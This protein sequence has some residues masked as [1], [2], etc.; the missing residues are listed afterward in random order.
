MA[1]GFRERVELGFESWGR[2]VAARPVTVLVASL[3]FAAA[4][5]SGLPHLRIDVSFEAFLPADDPVRVAY[6]S[7]REQFG[8]DE[9]V[10]IAAAPGGAVSAGDV[11]DLAFLEKLRAFHEAIEERIPYVDEITSLVN[12]RDTRGE[13]DLL[14][15]DDFL[16]PWPENEEQLA[17]LRERALANPLFRNNVISSDA[18]VTTLVL[19]LQLYSSIGAPDSENDVLAGFEAHTTESEEPPP[20]LSSAEE[21]EFVRALHAII[22]EFEG[23]DFVLHVSG[24]T[25]MIQDLSNAMFRDMPRFVGLAIGSIALLLFALF[26]RV[27]AVVTPLIVVGLSVAMTFG[28]MGWSDTSIHVP[29]QILPSF[30]LAVGVGDSVHLLTIFFERIRQGDPRED[31]LAYAL[32]HSGLAL[33]LTSVTTAG[34]LASFAG[35]GIAPVAALGLFA[36]IGVMIALAMSLT[37][38]PALMQLAPLSDSRGQA[39]SNEPNVLD[40]IL[41]G[42]GRFATRKPGVVVGVS[43][44]LLSLAAVGA[45]RLTLSHDPLSWLPE[46]S[47]IV[48]GTKYIDRAL[49]GSISFEILLETSEVGG[50]R[51]PDTLARMARLGESFEQTRRDG[52]V[53]AQTI[54]LADVVKE[55]NRALND[56]RAEAYVIPDDARLI[57]QELLLFENTGSDDLEQLV[58][59]EYRIARIAVRMPW[60]DAIRY[61]DFFD[62][63]EA[64]ATRILEEVGTASMTGVLAL[65]TRS[66]T[67]VVTSMA[68][69]YLL[70]FVIITPLMI[71]LLGNLRLG[72]LAMIPNL[73]PILLTLGLMGTFGLPLDA[74]SLLIG[75]I[76][77]GVAVD[78]TIHF[79]HNYR[80]YRDQ[81]EDLESAVE[82]TLQTTGRAM[83]IT[84]VV[85]A[86]GFFGFVLSSMQ[87]LT[88][89]GILVSFAVV[90]A[91]IADVL[92][93]PALL[94]LVERGEKVG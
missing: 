70:A 42:L 23:P 80:R 73:A 5:I 76:A 37:L 19:E 84:T 14:R 47:S 88:N 6:E 59:S 81:G 3:V 11:F 87:N 41:T 68:R 44:V 12:A 52:L 56:D 79:M 75:G 85:L 53:A 31:A 21:A 62:S 38:L 30:L 78:D 7:F 50:I 9:R 35:A 15:V 83:L 67:A 29:T 94:A 36:P 89:L 63:A 8:R 77:L 74:F 54:S 65:L 46:D 72:L 25:I 22:A 49:E 48:Q 57:S 1:A 16:D 69:S 20:L 28:L 13:G 27:V 39:A 93:A 24:S 90:M 66:V 71:L 33:V 26:R 91:F 58:D 86:V 55:I 64:A 17:A 51:Q 2:T 43:V 4:C 18:A 45:S 82:M 61:M 34:G 60:R 10:T 40:R 92:L 32:G